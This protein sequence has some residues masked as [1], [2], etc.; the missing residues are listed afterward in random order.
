MP[1]LD[2][3]LRKDRVMKELLKDLEMG[4][5]LAAYYIEDHSGDPNEQY[6]IDCKY[7]EKAQIAFKKL[8][9]IAK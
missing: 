3:V 2:P 4:L 8:Q 6:E 5:V 7:L 1:V 9:E